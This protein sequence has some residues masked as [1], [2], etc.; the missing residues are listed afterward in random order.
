MAFPPTIPPSTRTNATPQVDNHPGD[1]N[2]ISSALS[3]L[4][5]HA[6]GADTQMT[7]ICRFHGVQLSAADNKV[8]I[9]A[10]QSVVTTSALGA[11]AISFP[12]AYSLNPMVV[13]CNGEN[14]LSH[15]MTTFSLAPS[16]FQVLTRD[17]AGNPVANST[18]HVNWIAVGV[19][20]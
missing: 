1:H 9:Q 20:P 3:D 15:V 4:V 7:Q 19:R 6:S 14:G 17:P 13:A 5:N 18:V 8:L 10:D 2:M 16:S 12:E 11:S